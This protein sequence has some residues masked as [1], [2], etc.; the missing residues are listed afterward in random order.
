MNDVDWSTRLL[1]MKPNLEAQD[2]DGATPLHCAALANNKEMCQFLIKAGVDVNS[3]DLNGETPFDYA[4][5]DFRIQE[6]LRQN[7]GRS[8]NEA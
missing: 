5:D 7:G 1:R 2:E 6:I 4:M 8:G 3:V